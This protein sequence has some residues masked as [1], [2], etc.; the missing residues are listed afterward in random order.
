LKIDNSSDDLVSEDVIDAA[1]RFLMFESTNF[2]EQLEFLQLDPSNDLRHADLS[3]VDFSNSDLR[4]FDFTGANLQGAIGVDVQWDA[5]TIFSQADTSDS[6]FTYYIGKKQFFEAHPEYEERVERL[7]NEH[8]ANAILTIEAML[9]ADRNT[10]DALKIAR[11]VFD[12][13]KSTMVRSELL[14]YMSLGVETKEDHKAFIYNT[15]SR[16]AV[17]PSILRSGIR[18]L[19]SLYVNDRDAFNVMARFIG[20]PDEKVSQ[21]AAVGVLSSAQFIHAPSEVKNAL[22]SSASSLT[23]RAFVGR[24]AKAEF[25]QFAEILRDNDVASFIDFSEPISNE[26]IQRM[27]SKSLMNTNLR[28]LPAKQMIALLVDRGASLPRNEDPLIS[29][30]KM[31][32]TLI[33]GVGRKYGIPFRLENDPV[34]ITNGARGARNGMPKLANTL[35]TLL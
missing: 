34:E 16:F 32:K 3:Y 11:A 21:E 12:E 8:W 31:I 22:L 24:V 19:R 2:S 4:G 7:K 1:H 29:R 6:L 30:A 23:R 33:Q 18:T 13:T 9:R 28:G 17:Q 25:R 20:H 5:T 14:L 26:K 35:E 15:L 10:G 27:A